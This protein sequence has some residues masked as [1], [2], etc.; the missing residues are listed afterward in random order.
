MGDIG[1]QIAGDFPDL[2]GD[3]FELL[4]AYV[5]NREP[6]EDEAGPPVD[7]RTIM[8]MVADHLRERR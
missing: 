3:A 1:W 5:R 7:I 4:V 6:D 8:T 2:A